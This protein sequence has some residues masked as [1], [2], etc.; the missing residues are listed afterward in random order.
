MTREMLYD[1]I[2]EVRDELIVEAIETTP[3]KNQVRWL[4]FGSIAAAF[5]VVVGLGVG[6]FNGK[7]PWLHI[8]GNAAGAGADGSM[9][10]DSYAGP[11]F[12]LTAIAGGDGLR[13][14]RTVTYDFQGWMAGDFN[15]LYYGLP[16]TDSYTLTNPTGEDKTVTLLYPFAAD[17]Y[18]LERY[19]PALTV[20]G[21]EADAALLTG[22]YSALGDA[23]RPGGLPSLDD[24]ESWED[25]RT[26]LSDGRYQASATGDWPD[27]SHIP[28]TVYEVTNPWAEPGVGNKGDGHYNPNIH[29]ELEFDYSKTTVLTYGF[30]SYCHNPDGGT[31]RFGFDAPQPPAE[32]SSVDPD[33]YERERTQR[34]YLIVMGEP[35]DSF[36]LVGVST[37]GPEST[38]YLEWGTEI[39]ADL[40]QYQTDLESALRAA[41]EPLYYGRD[42]DGV[43]GNVED[44]PD[45]ELYFGLLKDCL[46]DAGLLLSDPEKQYD[47]FYQLENVEVWAYQRL[48]YLETEVTIP[49]GASVTVEAQ[50]LKEASY[51]HACHSK[52]DRD[53]YG[54]DLVTKL[55]TNLDIAVQTAKAVNIDGVEIVRQNFGFDWENGVDTVTLDPAVEHYYLEVRRIK[56]K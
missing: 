30:N 40:R 54:Y 47:L 34:H 31:A 44:T 35:L 33:F 14:E 8:G 46:L 1:A 11:V 42:W 19:Q 21:I 5:A 39:K 6:V 18:E 17:P 27:L 24:P 32:G 51:N 38:D 56:T 9:V 48:F 3:A 2:T 13:A 43:A 36:R 12:P 55:G 15:R 28:V 37:G 29:A 7:I 22:K 26:L 16:V 4:K 20:D 49:A 25:Y 50:M 41:A 10:F 45:F 52:H 53:L 23:G